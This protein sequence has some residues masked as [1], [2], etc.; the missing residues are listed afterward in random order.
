M[1]ADTTKVIYS[2][3]DKNGQPVITSLCSFATVAEGAL[4]IRWNT[5]PV[6][7]RYIPLQQLEWVD[8]ITEPSREK[9]KEN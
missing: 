8:I 9:D 5:S 6:K 2:P 1:A 3:V 7:V 4:Q